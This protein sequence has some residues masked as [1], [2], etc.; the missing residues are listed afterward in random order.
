MGTDHIKPAEALFPSIRPTAQTGLQEALSTPRARG[1]SRGRGRE[2]VGE[3]GGTIYRRGRHSWNHLRRAWHREQSEWSGRA[4][5]LAGVAKR[6]IASMDGEHGGMAAWQRQARQGGRTRGGTYSAVVYMTRVYRVLLHITSSLTY[7][8]L[9]G[10]QPVKGRWS[11]RV[12]RH[13][14]HSRYVGKGQSYRRHKRHM[15][16]G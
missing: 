2:P 3:F 9:Q 6:Y 13:Y 10:G 11:G 4:G 7:G 5:G 14:T 8:G 15:R 1:V 16:G 12:G